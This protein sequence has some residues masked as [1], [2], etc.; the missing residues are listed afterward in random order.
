MKKE[1]SADIALLYTYMYICNS[2]SSIGSILLF[3]KLLF[4]N[5]HNCVL[6]LSS[7]QFTFTIDI[8]F[9]MMSVPRYSAFSTNC[10]LFS[11]KL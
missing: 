5:P 3:K 9:A 6:A 4:I 10:I 7:F 1:S 8:L 11:G 2:L